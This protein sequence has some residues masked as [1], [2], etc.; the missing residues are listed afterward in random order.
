MVLSKKEF[1]KDIILEQQHNNKIAIEDEKEHITYRELHNTCTKISETIQRE[2]DCKNNRN[3]GIFL[4]NSV[5]YA[6]L[7]FRLHIWIEQLF[8]WR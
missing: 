8:Q 4:N 7:I 5:D 2:S 6:K 3:V 1:I